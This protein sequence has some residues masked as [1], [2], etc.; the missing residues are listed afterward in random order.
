MRAQHRDKPENRED[1][2]SAVFQSE[3]VIA[4]ALKSAALYGVMCSLRAL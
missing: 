2:V 1:L 3:Q 4:G